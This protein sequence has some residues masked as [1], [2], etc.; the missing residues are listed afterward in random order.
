M[1]TLGWGQQLQV[2]E[3][4]PT[5]VPDL[6]QQLDGIRTQRMFISQALE[7]E[8]YPDLMAKQSILYIFF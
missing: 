2:R 8:L 3:I 6:R 1:G 7:L 4:K 5:A